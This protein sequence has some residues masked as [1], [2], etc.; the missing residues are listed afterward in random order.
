[1]SARRPVVP[2]ELRGPL[3]AGTALTI[4]T[5]AFVSFTPVFRDWLYGDARFFENWGNWI[6]SH[7]VPYRD[8]NVEYPPLALPTFVVPVYL[9]KLFGYSGTWYF[10]F[11]I[12]LLVLALLMLA[13]VAWALAAAGAAAKVY[14]IVLVPLA[15]LELWRRGRWRAVGAGAGAALAV[16]VVVIGPF[17]VVG[18]H[19]VRWAVH[20]EASRPL[21]L[22]SVAASAF[23]AVHELTGAHIRVVAAASSH[24]LAGAWPDRAA[25]ASTYLTLAALLGVYWLYLRGGR[26]PDELVTACAAAVTAYIVFGKVFSPQFNI[27]LVPLVPLVGG[28]RGIRA[29]ALLVAIIGVTQIFEPY[30][31]VQYWHL[32][33]PWVTWTVVLRDVLAVALLAVLVWPATPRR[34]DFAPP[35]RP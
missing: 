5:W 20:R 19:G 10:W 14:P 17:A 16:L 28:R 23:A 12:E 27:W 2:P 15:L 8:F 11:R 9:R 32:D 1:M 24:G 3:L 4:A 26:T 6:T 21:D 25:T 33:T 7:R 18:A 13:A 34:L 35:T 22:E 29:S 30:R 31:Y